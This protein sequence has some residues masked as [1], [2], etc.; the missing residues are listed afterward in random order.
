MAYLLD[1][2]IHNFLPLNRLHDV[3]LRVN[4]MY[5]TS[6][7]KIRNLYRSRKIHFPSSYEP[8]TVKKPFENLE[9]KSVKCLYSGEKGFSGI[10]L[11][12]Y[13]ID[14]FVLELYDNKVHILMGSEPRLNDEKFSI[15]DSNVDKFYYSPGYGILE[16]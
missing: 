10:Y 9:I 6:F 14:K 4:L 2:N 8:N 1:L 15:G 11:S 5:L 16:N 3:L 12:R 7:P 13:S